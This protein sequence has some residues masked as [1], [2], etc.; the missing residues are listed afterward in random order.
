MAKLA[1]AEKPARTRQFV[2]YHHYRSGWRI[3]CSNCRVEFQVGQVYA[4]LVAPPNHDDLG[5]T[6]WWVTHLCL[7]CDAP[8]RERWERE[9][10]EKEI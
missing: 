8:Y 5:N 10:P 6:S 1:P 9:N 7:D 3:Y 4:R 2:T